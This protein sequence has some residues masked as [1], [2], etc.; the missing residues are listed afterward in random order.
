MNSNH[1]CQ[2]MDG[3]YISVDLTDSNVIEAPLFVRTEISQVF[4]SW[5]ANL[6]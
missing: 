4:Y 1:L 2:P 3:A 6:H 5:A